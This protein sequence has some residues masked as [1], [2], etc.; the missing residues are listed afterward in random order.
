MKLFAAT[1]IAAAAATDPCPTTDCWSYNATTN[2]CTVKNDCVKLTCGATSLDVSF[3]DDLFDLAAVDKSDSSMWGEDTKPQWDGS[4]S[5][6]QLSSNFGENGMSYSVADKVVNG[7][8]TGQ[9]ITFKQWVAI[10]GGGRQRRDDD[11]IL[12]KQINLGGLSVYTTPFGVGVLFECSYSTSVTVTSSAFKVSH[13]EAFGANIGV[14]NLAAGFSMSLT[15]MSGG[16]D[17]GRFVM[18]TDMKV[19][20][21]WAVKSLSGLTFYFQD[22]AVTH[23][24]VNMEII[25][26]G[27]YSAITNTVSVSE[28]GTLAE[29]MFKV[30]KGLNVMSTDQEITCVVNICER[31]QCAKPKYD[32][33]CPASS[34]GSYKAQ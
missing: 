4:S 21:E 2:H 19:G 5:K 17:S 6:W 7:T 23:G 10:A 25:K 9:D 15:S 8:V 12:G 28:T 13:V 20:V 1:L 11:M 22:C 16:T 18:G 30:F 3:G 27:C 33:D 29:F 14:G 32:Y 24:T 31:G 26:D 34:Y